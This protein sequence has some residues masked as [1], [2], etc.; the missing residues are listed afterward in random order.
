MERGWS[1]GYIFGNK[2]HRAVLKRSAE[3]RHKESM[4]KSWAGRK[5]ETL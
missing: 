3:G 4:I 1:L 5:S 2:L